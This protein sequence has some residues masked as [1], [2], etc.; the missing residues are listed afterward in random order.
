MQPRC[1]PRADRGSVTLRARSE[2]IRHNEDVLSLLTQQQVVITKV[3]F[4]HVEILR[5]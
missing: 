3:R 5:T 1:R 2:I 4:L